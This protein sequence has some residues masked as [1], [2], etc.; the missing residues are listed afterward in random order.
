MPTDKVPGLDGF[1]SQF[2]LMA[3]LIIKG[4]V[5]HVFH[6]LWSLDSRSFYLVNPS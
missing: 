1:T 5:M 2:Y 4:D 6:L 3:W